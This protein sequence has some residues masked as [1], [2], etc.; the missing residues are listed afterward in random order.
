MYIIH[1]LLEIVQLEIFTFLFLISCLFDKMLIY[2]CIYHDSDPPKQIILIMAVERLMTYCEWVVSG[3]SITNQIELIGR[4]LFEVLIEFFDACSKRAQ[5]LLVGRSQTLLI[6]F[7]FVFDNFC[8]CSS[9][10]FVF[11]L[12]FIFV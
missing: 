9:S 10:H 1:S 6:Y 4:C 11:T 12:F 2:V 7:I 5:K 8:L 3:L